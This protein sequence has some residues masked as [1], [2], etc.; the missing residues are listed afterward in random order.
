MEKTPGPFRLVRWS[1]IAGMI[2]SALALLWL[3]AMGTPLRAPLVLSV[4]GAILFTLM[5]AGALMGLLF[6]SSRS[7]LDDE[8]HR[9]D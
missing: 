7:G 9:E 3:D 6:H 8:V 2:A 4:V 5:A 1:A